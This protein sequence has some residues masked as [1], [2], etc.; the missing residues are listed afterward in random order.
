MVFDNITL[1]YDGKEYEV[2]D[3][4]LWGLAE[5]VEDVIS[6]VWLAPRLQRGDVPAGRVFRA[7]AAALQYAG[8]KGVTAKDISEGVG[9]KRMIEMAYELA[10]ILTITQ[11]SG[12]VDLGDPAGEGEAEDAEKKQAAAS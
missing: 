2:K 9:Y 8:A 12:D 10:G 11:P 1:Q 7:Y 4:A 5:A 6:M 3:G